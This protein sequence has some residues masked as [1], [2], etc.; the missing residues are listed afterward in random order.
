MYNAIPEITISL[1]LVRY[2]QIKC[3]ILRR[4]NVKINNSDAADRD[5]ESAFCVFLFLLVYP[6]QRLFTQLFST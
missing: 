4:H 5:V 3:N 1:Y 2:E 6:A